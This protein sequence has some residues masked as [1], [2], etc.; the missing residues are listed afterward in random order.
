MASSA[1]VVF[2]TSPLLGVNLDSKSSTAAFAL[3]TPVWANDGRKHIYLKATGTLAS[4]ANIT[5]GASGSAVS[6][7][8]A[9]V[10][11]YTVNTTGGVVANENFW[12]RATTV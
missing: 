12:A 5:A 7:A 6:A 10:A 8:S 1:S 9:G 4:T 2:A 3:L 11:T